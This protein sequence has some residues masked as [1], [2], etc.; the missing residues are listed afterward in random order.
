MAVN[1]R[2]FRTAFLLIGLFSGLLCAEDREPP[3]TPT[4]KKPAKPGKTDTRFVHPCDGYRKGMRGRGNFGF[5]IPKSRN[6]VFGGTYHLAEDIWLKGGTPVKS[7][8]DGVVVYSDFSQTWTDEK[9]RKHWN[10]GNVIIIE[11]KL[12][13]PEGEMEFICSVYIHLGKDRKVKRGDPVKRGERIGTI[14]KDRSEENG[15]YPAHLHFGIHKGPYVQIPPSWKEEVIK[16]AA[17]Q[18]LPI[19]PT[20]RVKGEKPEPPPGGWPMEIYKGEVET[21]TLWEKT[22]AKVT[23]KG[24]EKVSILPLLKGSSSP[25]Y[26]SEEIMCWCNGY[27]NKTTLKEWL[28]PSDWIRRHLAK[29][30]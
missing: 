16:V 30:K 21:V 12:E 4:E 28:K 22:R 13:P 25:H 17:S 15:F 2:G 10:L 1:F 26:K 5:L 18:G 9:G 19:A 3:P 14:G 23:F 11:H 27:G 20:F 29:D 7:I 24:T 8:G 6:P